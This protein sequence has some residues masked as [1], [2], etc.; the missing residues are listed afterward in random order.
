M[1]TKILVLGL[2]CLIPLLAWP[3]AVEKTEEEFGFTGEVRDIL[4][5]K[6]HPKVETEIYDEKDILD[7]VKVLMVGFSSLKLEDTDFECFEFVTYYYE[8]SI[9][10]DWVAIIVANYGT[11]PAPNTKI[12]IEVKGP[13]SSKIEITRTIPREAV[14]IYAFKFNKRFSKETIGVYELIGMIYH[15]KVWTSKAVTSLYIDEIW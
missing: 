6:L 8:E 5:K 10:D 14:M 15:H 3:Q 13:K 4:L 7:K 1:K 12:S 11:K 9:Y 2:L